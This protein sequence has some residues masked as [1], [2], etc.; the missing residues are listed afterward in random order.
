MDAVREQLGLLGVVLDT[1]DIAAFLR[2]RGDESGPPQLRGAR[3]MMDPAGGA[4]AAS[5]ARWSGAGRV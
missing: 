2:D 1:E 5:R 4:H 3:A